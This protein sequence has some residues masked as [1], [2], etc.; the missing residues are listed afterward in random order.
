MNFL[1]AILCVITWRSLTQL[2]LFEHNLLVG[3]TMKAWYTTQDKLWRIECAAQNVQVKMFGLE[4]ASLKI[5]QK[6]FNTKLAFAMIKLKGGRWECFCKYIEQN[7][8]SCFLS[9]QSTNKSH[10]AVVA[11]NDCQ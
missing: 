6:L 4:Y 11:W 7:D 2:A 1:S 10:L 9:L 5:N 8:L 3:F